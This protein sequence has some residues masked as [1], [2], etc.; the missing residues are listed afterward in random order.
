[1]ATVMD[2][3]APKALSWLVYTANTIGVAQAQ[4]IGLVSSV[5]PAADLRSAGEETIAQLLTRKRDALCAVKQFITKARLLDFE[6]AADYGAN[7]LA[8]TL[9]SR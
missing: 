3:V 7:L 1:M 5:V 2:R 4:Q 9:S 6:L 8:I